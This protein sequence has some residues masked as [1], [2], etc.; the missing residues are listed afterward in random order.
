MFLKA[1]F[2][3]P[4]R[5]IAAIVFA[6][7][8]LCYGQQTP[9]PEQLMQA[10]HKVA[11]LSQAAPYALTAT[12]VL[13][14]GDAKKE[15]TGRLTIYRDH[16]RSRVEFETAGYHEI[17]IQ[18][19]K[20]RYVTPGPSF[21]FVSDL[22]D[23]DQS[24]DPSPRDRKIDP[25]KIKFGKVVKKIIDGRQT[26]CFDRDLDRFKS[27]LCVD[28][29]SSVLLQVRSKNWSR[30]FFDYTPLAQEMV[31]RRVAIRNAYRA[32]VELRDIAVSFQSIDASQFTP[33]DHAIELEICDHIQAPQPVYTPEPSLSDKETRDHT[34]ET[35]LVYALIAKDGTMADAQVVN[36]TGDGLDARAERAVR[37]WK[38]KAATCSGRPIAIEMQVEV[39]F[40]LN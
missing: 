39:E 40:R 37:T 6:G 25:G 16:D 1:L 13:N 35:V 30:E 24:W 32:P 14:P 21:L 12:V 3:H 10:A 9:S 27:T 11:D 22:S 20:K 34:R 38:F 15:T 5:L 18:D 19:G 17:R 23:F 26:M 4:I 33:P 8:M 29:G 7:G 36:P 31:P 28:A 2:C